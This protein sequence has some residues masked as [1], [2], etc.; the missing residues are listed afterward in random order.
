MKELDRVNDQ[1]SV[2]SAKLAKEK[3]R[4]LKLKADLRETEDN[5]WKLKNS[6]G[7]GNQIRAREMATKKQINKLEKL[8]MVTRNT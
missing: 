4:E 7:N 1:Q 3:K 5:I 8:V 2:L 6:S